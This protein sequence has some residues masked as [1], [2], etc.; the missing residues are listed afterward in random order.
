MCEE[1]VPIVHG[2]MKHCHL[3]SH[4]ELYSTFV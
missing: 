4:Q 2:E 3:Y 1:D